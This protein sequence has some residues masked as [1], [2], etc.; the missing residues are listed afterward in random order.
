MAEREFY[1]NP[2]MGYELAPEALQVLQAAGYT[3]GVVLGLSV[4][5]F[6]LA[7]LGALFLAQ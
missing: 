1:S 7:Q 5:C 2:M 4:F 6:G 3:F